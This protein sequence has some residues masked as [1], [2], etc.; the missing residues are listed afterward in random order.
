MKLILLT[1]FNCAVF[2]AVFA[3]NCLPDGITFTSQAQ[4]DNFVANNPDCTEIDGSVTINGNGISNLN[5]LSVVTSIGGSFTIFENGALTSLSGLNN[6]TSV[7]GVLSIINN[8]SLTSL[9]AL[10]NL[11]SVGN[12]F[13]GLVI[14]NNPSLTSLSGL[15]SINY[16][17]LGFLTIEN[18]NN[19]CHCNVQ[20][21]CGFVNTNP[22]ATNISGNATGCNSVSQIQA[23]CLNPMNCFPPIASFTYTNQGQGAVD[24]MD[25]STNPIDSWEWD[26]GDGNSSSSQNPSYI[27]ASTGTYNV[28]L[29]VTN[30][31]GSDYSTVH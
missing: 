19:L 15:G 16:L 7:G 29:T 14:M 12:Q 2:C 26:F 10:N 21:V 11:T 17:N 23:A 6:L 8:S 31:V 13:L 3:Q 30:N 5:G 25:Q 20:S 1:F 28:C 22:N 18:C 9:S 27:F 4:I 24:F